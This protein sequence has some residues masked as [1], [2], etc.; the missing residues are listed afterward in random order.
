MKKCA[1]LLLAAALPAWGGDLP[2]K[3]SVLDNKVLCVRACRVTDDFSEQFRTARPTNTISGII[4]DLRFADGDRNAAMNVFPG[5]KSPLV[6]LING[7]TRGAA[8]ALAAQLR[9]AGPAVVVI[10]SANP[11]ET[12]RPDI[13]VAV[14][15]DDE[16]KFLEN[17]YFTAPAA[18]FS[19]TNDLLPFVDHMSEAEL[20]RK[21]V[22]DGEDVGDDALVP[23]P[24]SSPVIRDPALAR[25]V[26]LLKALAV[27]HPARG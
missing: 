22:K 20:V 27:L 14:S 3:I 1:I 9:A 23:R 6:I 24:E 16:K 7:Q 19:A 11:A 4:L 18:A 15:A 21:K 5:R 17:P 26:D 8:S 12:I 13:A 10:G 25:A 2:V